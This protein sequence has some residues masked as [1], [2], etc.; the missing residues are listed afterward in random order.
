MITYAVDSTRSSLR[1]SMRSRSMAA[2]PSLLQNATTPPPMSSA[3]A[4]P[5]VTASSVRAV[6]DRG[7]LLSWDRADETRQSH[8][9]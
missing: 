4:S 1:P 2:G 3:I 7:D 5:M 6:A 9:S 8:I